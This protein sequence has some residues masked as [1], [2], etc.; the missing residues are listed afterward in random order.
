M[1]ERQ[2]TLV[3]YLRP[4]Q[5]KKIFQPWIFRQLMKLEKSGLL[6]KAAQAS[7]ASHAQQTPWWTKHVFM[8]TINSLPDLQLSERADSAGPEAISTITG[9]ATG[10]LGPYPPNDGQSKYDEYDEAEQMHRQTLELRRKVS[11]PEHPHTLT[12]MGNLGSTLTSQGKYDE[13]RK[14]RLTQPTPSS[15]VPFRRDR[16]FVHR[17]ILSEIQ[18]RC[19][20]PASRVALVGLGGVG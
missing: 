1:V 17:E 19:F 12:S 15:T 14:Y 20:Q 7:R 11:G 5:W 16:D 18:R 9:G 6:D 4:K 8:E 13:S 2:P 10:Y 3:I